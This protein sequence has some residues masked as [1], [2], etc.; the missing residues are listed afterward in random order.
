MNEHNTGNSIDG[1]GKDAWLTYHTESGIE[2][3]LTADT[4]VEL[5]ERYS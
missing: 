2:K 4:V 5:I 1:L 3:Q